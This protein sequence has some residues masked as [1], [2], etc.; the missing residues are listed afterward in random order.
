M[1]LGSRLDYNLRVNKRIWR[2]HMQLAKV[3]GSLKAIERLEVIRQLNAR[4]GWIN[5]KLY[6]LMFS[7]DLY[8]L[9]YERI[10]SEPGNMTPGTDKETLDGFSMDEVYQIVQEMRTEKYQCKPVRRTYI[11]KSNG[12]LRKLG[13]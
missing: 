8:V 10:K 7:P 11:P 1:A 3:V 9:A 2:G 12:K 4:S 5:R 13:I 6:N